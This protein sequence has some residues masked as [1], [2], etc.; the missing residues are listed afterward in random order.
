MTWY[1]AHLIL[2]TKFDDGVQDN[3]PVWENVVLIEA[4]SSDE[5]FD[6]ADRK[7]AAEAKSSVGSRYT[8]N[9]RPATFVFAGVRKLNECLEDF[10]PANREADGVEQD[11]TEVTYSSFIVDSEAS[12][13][14][15]VADKDVSLLYEGYG[16]AESNSEAA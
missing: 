4:A 10:D 3:Y 2:Y 8:Y 11:G 7:G 1:A 15:L 13:Q 6:K 5:A 14:R 16:D 12:L 9:G